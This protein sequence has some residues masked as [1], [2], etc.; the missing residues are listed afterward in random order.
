M[1][2]LLTTTLRPLAKVP[3]LAKVWPSGQGSASGHSVAG[4][5]S[6]G[7]PCIFHDIADLGATHAVCA[8]HGRAR[9]APRHVELA[10]GTAQH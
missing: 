9:P 5:G 3:P 1:H 7:V 8:A 10:F 2:S 6:S 4:E